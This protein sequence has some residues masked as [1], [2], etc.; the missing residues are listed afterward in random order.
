MFNQNSI[1]EKIINVSNRSVMSLQ[2][3]E[4]DDIPGKKVHIGTHLY[5]L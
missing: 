5:V 4:D 3:A 1:V 2:L